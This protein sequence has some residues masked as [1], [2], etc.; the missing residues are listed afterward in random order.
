MK[1][2]TH[3]SARASRVILLALLVS[4]LAGPAA[5]QQ[6]QTVLLQFGGS[7]GDSI[8]YQLETENEVRLPE[9]V[10]GE[11]TSASSMLLSQVIERTA[12]DTIHTR[13]TVEDLSLE[14]DLEEM[15]AGTRAVIDEQ[16]D[17]IRGSSMLMVTTRS[18]EVLE[19][20]FG[21]GLTGGAQGMEQALRE[22]GVSF[23][24]KSIAVGESWT[25]EGA[26]NMAAFG[27]PLPGE[28]HSTAE[29]TLGE[30]RREE[31]GLVAVIRG[32]TNFDFVSPPE[33][34]SEVE[35]ELIGS[36]AEVLLFDVDRG[37]LLR[38]ET[39][40]ELTLNISVPSAG[41]SMTMYMVQRMRMAVVE[42]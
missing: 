17:Q 30:L 22:T 14:L 19:M 10:G 37:Q 12:G 41:E 26:M 9:E 27:V 1:H 20:M 4:G 33:E 13:V 18:G 11:Q 32:D 29:Y 15:D 24:P 6:T 38:D 3:A 36:G 42:D 25:R 21:G 31:D 8:R 35:M 16:Q 5:C 39:T 23:P 34:V 7:E 28:I 40:V 2:F